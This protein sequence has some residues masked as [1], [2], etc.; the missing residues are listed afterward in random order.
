MKAARSAFVCGLFVF[1]TCT[2]FATAAD[3]ARTASF[4]EL[5]NTFTNFLFTL[6]VI[7]APILLVV[8][9]VI[10]MTAAGD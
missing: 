7:I 9:G 4:S 6:A 10:F 3:D 5:I 8:A 2:M 1:G